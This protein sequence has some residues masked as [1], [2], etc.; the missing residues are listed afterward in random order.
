MHLRF[1][2]AGL[3]VI[4][5]ANA[6]TLYLNGKIVT[7]DAQ[8]RVAEAMAVDEGKIVAVGSN[9]EIRQLGGEVVDLG[10]K[11]VVPGFIETHCHSIGATRAELGGGYQELYSIGGVQEWVRKRAE[12]TPAGTW[13]EVP[14][15]EITRLK[16]RRFPTPEELDA[17]APKHPV[18]FV[19]V[20]KSV[21][22]SAGWKALGVTDE[23][24]K[25]PGGEVM[26]DGGRPVL[27]RGGQAA[28]RALIPLPPAPSPAATRAKLRELLG[29][30]NS[31]GIT[32]IFERAT[33]RAGYDLFRDLEAKAELTARVRTTFRFSAKDAAGAEGFIKKLGLKPGE[34]DDW[35][36]ATCMK[37]TVDGGIHWG[38]TWLSE[39]HGPARAAFY[40]NTD[41]AYTG[42]HFYTPEQMRDIFGAVNRLGWPMSAHVTGDGGAMAVL[43]AVADVA[44]EQPNIK[45]RRFNLIHCYFPD[46]AMAALAKEVNAGV[47]TQE[48]LFYR[49]S[50]FIAKIYGKAWAERFL[51]LASWVKAGVP[52]A[53]NS[54]HMIG[55]D[56]DHAMN[57]F[58]PFL[59]LYC[60]VTRKNDLGEVQGPE[61]KL[62]RLNAL[63][64]VT[65]WAAWLSF[66]ESKLGT[67]EKGK[68]ADFVV[69]DRD[70]LTCPEEEI[71]VMKPVRTV[72]GGKTVWGLNAAP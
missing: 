29:I 1:L 39:P 49:D 10:G 25:V 31:V 12:K 41:P 43:R 51:G 55:F 48:Y 4:T 27:M 7:L 57:A 28:V 6:G 18:L 20:T 34:G 11:M 37:I 13:I 58:N 38:T 62:S 3:G 8:E 36:R 42:E 50:D 19:S 30:Y 70:Y 33:D 72:V 66:D 32:S 60:A 23:K 35:V 46:A 64:T 71:R 40:R 59:M 69:L 44:K 68:L 15:N 53:I 24:S 21:L 2:L 61:Q 52:V 9:D 14:R 26:W 63:R 45:E 16:E 65:Q 56:P 5:S 54:D 22:N 47:D 67:L 17:A